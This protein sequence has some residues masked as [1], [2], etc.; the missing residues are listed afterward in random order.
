ME[1]ATIIDKFNLGITTYL[2]IRRS[3]Q[4]QNLCDPFSEDI[5]TIY[6]VL[7]FNFAMFLK[8]YKF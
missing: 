4:L 3:D 1:T 5:Q 8:K 7:F 6:L 2:F